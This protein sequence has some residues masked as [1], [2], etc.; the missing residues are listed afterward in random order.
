MAT[1]IAGKSGYVKIG[2][3]PAGA[4]AFNKWTF[5]PRCKILPKNTFVAGG[6]D[7]NIGGFIGADVR[8]EGP[9]DLDQTVALTVGD[10]ITV[11]LGITATGPVEFNLD[12]R[13]GD[14]EVTNDAEDEPHLVISGVSKGPFSPAVPQPTTRAA[15]SDDRVRG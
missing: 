14:I 11:A 1:F 15:S 2:T 8:M 6:F 10:V 7:D 5:H 4:W 3:P 13:I 12:V 9:W